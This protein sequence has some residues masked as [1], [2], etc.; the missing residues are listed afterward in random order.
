MTLLLPVATCS[1]DSE[2]A[3]QGGPWLLQ[4][5]AGFNTQR[6]LT[7]GFGGLSRLGWKQALCPCWSLAFVGDSLGRFVSLNVP[8]ISGSSFRSVSIGQCSQWS[9]GHRILNLWELHGVTRDRP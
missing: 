1:C 6:D 7:L 9:A 2:L 3:A 5:G 4:Q 8:W